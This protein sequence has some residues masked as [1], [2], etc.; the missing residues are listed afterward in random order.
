MCIA[1]LIPNKVRATL[2]E[3]SRYKNLLPVYLSQN[4][5]PITKEKRGI[6]FPKYY[7]EPKNQKL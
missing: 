3:N 4:K 5:F 6:C 2:P 1:N 7:L